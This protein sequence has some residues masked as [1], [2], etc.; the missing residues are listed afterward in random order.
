MTD[1]KFK[2]VR[3]LKGYDDYKPAT[4]LERVFF[5]LGVAFVIIA[6]TGIDSI[7]TWMGW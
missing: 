1:Q 7:L 3:D 4:L 2:K 5:V 6:A